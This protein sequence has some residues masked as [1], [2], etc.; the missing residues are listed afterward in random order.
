MWAIV[1]I[2]IRNCMSLPSGIL[3]GRGGGR[4]HPILVVLTYHAA[5]TPSHLYLTKL[6]LFP[7]LEYTPTSLL[8]IQSFD[9]KIVLSIIT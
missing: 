7:S 5:Q 2:D 8:Y 1:R 6:I 4:V 3:V 9:N